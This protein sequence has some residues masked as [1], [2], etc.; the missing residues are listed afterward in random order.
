MEEL[1]HGW[2]GQPR[3][4]LGPDGDIICKLPWQRRKRGTHRSANHEFNKIPSV[5]FDLLHQFFFAEF[6]GSLPHT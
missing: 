6:H 1:A 5:E 2:D 4:V 3:K